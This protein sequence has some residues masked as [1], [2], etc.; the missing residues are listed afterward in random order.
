MVHFLSTIDKIRSTK[1]VT[2]I[3]GTTFE[4]NKKTH[5]KEGKKEEVGKVG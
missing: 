3:E 4:N 1:Q 5:E 2:A